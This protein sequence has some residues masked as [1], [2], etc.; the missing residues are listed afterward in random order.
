MAVSGPLAKVA[1]GWHFDT[2]AGKEEVLA[3]RIGR[4][5][6]AV[7]R[8]CRTYVAGQQIYAERGHDGQPAGLYARRSGAIR[9]ARMACSGPR[10]RA[11][12]AVRWVT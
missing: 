4:N 3:R 7:I 11:R 5:E 12:S 6:L 1:G 10:G 8:V 2:A 9:A